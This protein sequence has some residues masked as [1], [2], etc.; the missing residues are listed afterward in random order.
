M[1]QI[2]LN[3]EC[4]HDETASRHFPWYRV[5]CN[6]S[7]RLAINSDHQKTHITIQN[8]K[9]QNP[10]IESIVSHLKV[11]MLKA[12]FSASLLFAF[13]VPAIA[14]DTQNRPQPTTEEI[15][16]ACTQNR[17]ETLPNP[18]VDVSPRDWA[19]KAVLTMHYC[20]AFRQAAP[21]SLF[22]RSPQPRQ[23]QNQPNGNSSTRNF[24]Q[25]AT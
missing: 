7:T 12:L 5:L 23:E 6:R 16:Q 2:N 19:Y 17:A 21:R 20:G 8:P 10:N 13:A 3:L 14:Q 9:T 24:P 25:S 22:E 4:S 15:Y 1:G 11:T 18:F